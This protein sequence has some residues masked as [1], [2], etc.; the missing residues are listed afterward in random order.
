MVIFGDNSWTFPKSFTFQ[1]RHKMNGIRWIASYPKA[2]NTWLRCMLAAYITDKAPQV[3]NDAY[4]EVPALEGMLRFGDIPPMDSTE[5]VLVKTHLRADVP[6]LGL[7][8][9]ATAK[10]LYLVRNPRDTLLSAMRMLSI[11]RDGVAGSRAYARDFIASEGL[12]MMM[13]LS[14]RAGI[15]SWPENVRSWTES[16]RDCFPNADVLTVRYEDLRED[17]IARLSEIVGFLDLGSPVDDERIRRAVAACTLE[18]MREL[19]KRSKQTGGGMSPAGQESSSEFVG[20]GRHN[21]SLSVLGEDIESAYQEL[22]HGDSGFAY[23]AKQ[24]GYAG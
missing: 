2:G 19:E 10:A 3:W 18:R 7:C 13:S 23:Y 16:S 17:P 8:S 21:Q 12:S 15:G 5:P 22:L 20:E 6:V 4:A 24:Y 1:G 9:E 14:P 11:S